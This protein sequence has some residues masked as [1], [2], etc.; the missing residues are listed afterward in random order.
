MDGNAIE[1]EKKALLQ[2]YGALGAS[3]IL[4][5]V[6]TIAAAALSL[7]LLTGVMIAAY[8]MRKKHEIGSLSA[9]HMTFIIRTIWISSLFAIVTMTIGCAYL[10]AFIDNTPLSPCI[11]HL[12]NLGTQAAS[13]D[14]MALMRVFDPCLDDYTTINMKAFIVSG[15]IAAA[16]ILIY[17]LVRYVRGLSRAMKGYRVAKPLSWL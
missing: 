4:S 5:V 14:M 15:F 17:F 1:K 8:V 11:S 12:M 6:P 10:L 9:N 2:I 13:M 16:P 7:I 3:L